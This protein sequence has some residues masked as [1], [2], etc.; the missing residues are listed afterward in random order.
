MDNTGSFGAAAGGMSPELQAAIQRRQGG[1]PSG[2]MGQTT[3]SAPTNNPMIQQPQIQPS[4]VN[5]ASLGVPS[6][7]P[8]PSGG[9]GLPINVP[10]AQLIIKALDQRLRSISKQEEGELL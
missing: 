3:N 5:P 6:G 2:P 9:A 4:Q 10:E 7:S 1:N 8:R